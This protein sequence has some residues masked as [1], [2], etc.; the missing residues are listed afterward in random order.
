MEASSDANDLCEKRDETSAVNV[1]VAL[2]AA[3]DRRRAEPGQGQGH[4][5]ARTF[6]AEILVR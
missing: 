5:R 6:Q 1:E 2:A 4:P 3:F